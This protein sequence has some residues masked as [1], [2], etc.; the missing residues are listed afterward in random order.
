MRLR[1]CGM[2]LVELMVAAAIG[3]MVVLAATA[4][5]LGSRQLFAA[6]AEAQSV[7]DSLRFAAAVVR[8]M[9]RQA[10]YTD[11]A[12]DRVGSDGTVVIGSSANLMASADDP[13]DLDIVGASNARV[14]FTGESH[15]S[16]NSRGVNGSDSL[17]VRF[18]GRSRAGGGDT[19]PD[20]TMVDCMGI[21][22]PGPA[23][24]E[25]S[26]ADRAWSFFFVAEAADKEP[27]LY[28]KYRSDK[29]GAFRSEPLA[30]GIEVFKVVYAYDGNGDSVPERWLDAAQLEALAGSTAGIN[31]EWRKVVGL[32]IGMVARSGPGI[33]GAQT[34]V[35]RLYPLGADFPSVSFMPPAD[36]RLRRTSTFT[37]MLRNVMK[38]P[39]P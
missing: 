15:G 16:H 1:Q 19:E 36:G 13:S 37:V 32:R 14:S 38:E 6:N 35:E 33:G 24:G 4:T 17:R 8:G 26:L 29:E 2:T 12:P 10:G 31:S 7:E 20:G 34:Q 3:L 39:A 25:P 22:Q 27:E 5:F 23:D 11:Y 9:V 28:C 18:F 30:R 21:A